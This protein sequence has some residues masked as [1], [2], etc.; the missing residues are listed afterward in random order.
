MPT[1]KESMMNKVDQEIAHHF[2]ELSRLFAM[3]ANAE[4]KQPELVPM[5]DAYRCK[6]GDLAVRIEGT[7]KKGPYAGQPFV[8]YACPRDKDSK[9]SYWQWADDEK[10]EL[11][12]AS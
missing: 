5:T 4:I 1:R 11:R 2:N 3:K 7:R 12:R 8:A 6:H 10:P 9:C